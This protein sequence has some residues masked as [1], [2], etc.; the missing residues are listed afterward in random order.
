VVV[1][2]ALRLN[3]V[4][5]VGEVDGAASDPI[6]HILK[7]IPLNV[8]DLRVYADRPQFTLNATSCEPFAAQ[9]TIWAD[10]TALEP[11]AQTPAGL[12]SRYQAAGCAGLGFKPKL[13]LKLK[14]GTKRGKFPALRAVYTPREGDANLSRLA[15]TFPHSEFIEQGHFRTICTRVQFAAGDG[16]GEQCPAGSVY[17]HIRA[18]SPLLAEPLT[19][20]VYLRSSSH[21]LPDAVFAL[22]GLVNIDVVVRIDSHKGGLRATVEGSPDAPVSRAIVDMQGGKKGLFVNSTNLCAA[23]HR[24]KANATGQNAKRYTSR[25]LVRA[26]C[27][28]AHKKKHGAHRR[29]GQGRRG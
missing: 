10:G 13:G 4:T 15:L 20:P 28:R 17:G 23:K 11:L 3:P 14:G 5:H 2:E 18:W 27:G 8:R 7:G 24:A 9:S 25:P 29:K 6:P 19:G 26:K 12:S 16:D 22:H 1:R 21:N